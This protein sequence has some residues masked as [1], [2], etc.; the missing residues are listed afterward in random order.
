MQFKTIQRLL[1]L[2]GMVGLT[3]NMML[4]LTYA[5]SVAIP[6]LVI[7]QFKI[8]S[9][10][11]Q[12][13]SLYN[14]TD[15]SLDMTKYQLQYF[16]NYDLTKATSSRQL[17]L[18]GSL[19]AHGYYMISDD[20]Q[21]LCYQ[22]TV[23]SS[24]LGFSSIAGL[25]EIMSSN[26]V[27]PG[28]SVSPVLQDYVG[29]SKTATSGAQ[30]LPASTNASLLRQPLTNQYNP[31]IASPG[32]GT[33]LAVQ[34]DA[35]NS[36]VLMAV[37]S[38]TTKVDSPST[39]NP[40]VSSPPLVIVA[41]TSE[42]VAEPLANTPDINIGLSTPQITEIL[43][44][45]LATGNDSTNEYIELYNPNNSPFDVSDYSLQAGTTTL[46][47]YVLP[48]GSLLAPMSY[49]AYYS[50]LTGLTLSNSGGQ[51]KLLNSELETI[52]Q[53]A[54]YDGAKDGQAWAL[55]ND[56]WIWTTSATPGSLNIINTPVVAKPNIKP[57]VVKSAS[58]TAKSSKSTASAPTKAINSN[59]PVA[60]PSPIHSWTLAL[61][62]SLALLYGAYEY[63][64]DLGNQ[65]HKLTRYFS[66]WRN[67][68][69]TFA[70]WRSHRI[71]QRSRW[72]QNFFRKRLSKGYGQ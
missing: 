68:R 42:D 46:H 24:T 65:F 7:S 41:P 45:P 38:P 8:T 29:W 50:K 56:K 40:I 51:V 63:R 36:C 27:S 23:N 72:W 62:A 14:T 49:T 44:N 5:E 11:G 6:S 47:T 53:T 9:S 4:G 52:S 71:G 20:S 10:N 57:I 22:M 16:N 33:W 13:V 21:L 30:T 43:P 48:S 15:I 18:T 39:I 67:Y 28:G 25:V 60:N 59:P 12:F 26:Q 69:P 37:S 55:A 32:S 54:I 70:W 35:N 64:T 31:D 34:P 66:R 1:V 3:L 2:L 17:P 58:S 61:V 19:P